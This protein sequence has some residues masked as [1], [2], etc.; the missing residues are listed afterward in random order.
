MYNK[1]LEGIRIYLR[2]VRESDV[3]DEYYR[4]INDPEV[5]RFLESRFYPQ[6]KNDILNYVKKMESNPDEVFFAICIKDNDKHIG[7][8]KLGPINWI[9]RKGDISLVIGKK[10]FWGK[11]IATEAIRLV[12]NFAFNLLNLHK[13]C[14]GYYDS[15]I[16]S[17]KAFSKCGFEEEGS[18]TQECFLNGVFVNSIRTGLI[19]RNFTSSNK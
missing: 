1:Y 8:I 12:V 15:N 17:A 19:N 14:A 13:L 2:E 5:N 10:E 6:S 18:Y 3:N 11:G 4:W 16:G 7:N 9:H